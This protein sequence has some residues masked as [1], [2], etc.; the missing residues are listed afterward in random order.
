MTVSPR[1]PRS[2]GAPEIPG[3]QPARAEIKIDAVKW[4]AL[5]LASFTQIYQ[6]KGKNPPCWDPA[7]AQTPVGKLGDLSYVETPCSRCCGQRVEVVPGGIVC[8]LCGTPTINE[9]A[10]LNIEKLETEPEVPVDPAVEP[11]PIET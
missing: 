2:Q 4:K 8:A 9:D 1:K 11:A 3:R 5:H 6:L 10:E 7:L